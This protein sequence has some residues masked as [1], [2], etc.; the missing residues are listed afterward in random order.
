MRK[1]I[2][3]IGLAFLCIPHVYS[4][5]KDFGLWT[6]FGVEKKLA[7]NIELD[8]GVAN[9][10]KDN[11][12][13]RDESFADIGISYRYADFAAGFGYRFTDN[14]DQERDYRLSH[15]F[16]WQ[17]RYRPDWERFSFDYRFRFQ[18]QY[19][20]IQ[21]SENGRI[22]DNFIRNRLKVSY[23]IKKSDFEPY[24]SYEYFFRLNQMGPDQ[25]ERRRLTLGLEYEINKDNS[26]GLEWILHETFN[27]TEPAKLYVIALEYKLEI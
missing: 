1:L 9:R 13:Q 17:I 25:F 18:S 6:S 3:I 16:A 27:V 8:F 23:N 4:Q 20:S 12:N 15:R 21:S 24:A 5:N 10:Q 11:L 14:Y 22:P 19:F 7:E 2:Y 26:L